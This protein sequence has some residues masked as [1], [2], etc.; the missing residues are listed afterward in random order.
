MVWL[1]G[2]PLSESD[3]L[4]LAASWIDRA[5]ADTALLRRVSSIEGAELI[6]QKD[7]HDYAGVVFPY[8]RP[9][10]SH[11]HEFRLRRDSPEVTHDRG[12]KKTVRRYLSPP[13]RGNL[14]Y[15]VPGTRAEWLDDTDLPIVLTEGEKKAIALSRLAWHDIAEGSERPHSL[16]LAVSGVWNWRGSIGKEPGPNG[17]RLDVKGVIPDFNRIQWAGRKTLIAFDS[18]T[19]T[20]DHVRAARLE[21]A[22]HLVCERSADVCFVEIP[23]RGADNKTGIDDYLSAVGPDRTLKLIGSAKSA[24]I[25]QKS[26]GQ[27]SILNSILSEV[28][29]FRAPDLKPFVAFPVSG[30][31]ETW[32][33]RSQGFRNWL[34]E[35]FYHAEGKPPTLQALQETLAACEAKCQF[36]GPSMALDRHSSNPVTRPGQ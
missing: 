33:V 4:A 32:A 14:L 2:T 5:S 35:K 29:F 7:G 27:T 21:L 23:T 36:G 20:N 15:F 6:G 19:K 9:G 10:E 3:Y 34:T 18:D 16:A 11:P 13:G 17:E 1:P 22:R 26:P 24:K 31:R 30:H 25:K 12:I 28:E 8:I